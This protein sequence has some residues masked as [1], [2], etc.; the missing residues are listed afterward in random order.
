M[1]LLYDLTINRPKTDPQKEVSASESIIRPLHPE[2]KCSTASYA[3]VL[4]ASPLAMKS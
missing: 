2:D 3:N 1:G 4:F